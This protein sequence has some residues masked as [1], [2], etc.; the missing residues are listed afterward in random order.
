MTAG[1][2]PIADFPRLDRARRRTGV[3][4]VTLAAG[5]IALLVAG[6]VGATRKTQRTVQFL[7]NGQMQP[8]YVVF[9]PAGER[10]A[11]EF[12]RDG[13]TCLLIEIAPGRLES[14]E[15]FSD[16]TTRPTP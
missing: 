12:G 9:K 4:R 5:L 14:I 1:S 10:H 2:I 6:A 7:P 3:I 11:D 8:H 13:G 15:P 16:I